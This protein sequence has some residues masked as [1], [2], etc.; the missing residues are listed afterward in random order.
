[1]KQI[2]LGCGATCSQ[3]GYGCMSLEP[4]I[5]KMDDPNFSDNDALKV[6]R[7]ARELGVTMFDSSFVYGF[8]HNET[9]LGKF[10][11]GIV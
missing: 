7:R 11:K 2:E 10:L 1:M 3:I 6:L 5:Y 4:S 9:L 8:G